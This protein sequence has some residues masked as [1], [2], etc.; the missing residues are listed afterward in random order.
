MT[1]LSSLVALSAAAA[2]VALQLPLQRPIKDALANPADDPRHPRPLVTS[3]LLQDTID[4]RRLRE[5]AEQLYALAQKSEDEFNHPTR[6]IGSAGHR[7]TLEYIKSEL[8]SLGSYYNVSEQEFDAYTGRVA[9]FRLVVMDAVPNTT[10]AFAL[11]P[12]TTNNEPVFGEVVLVHGT[13]CHESDYPR[14]ARSNIVL[15]KRG[16]C[17]FGEKSR[18]AGEAGAV[19]AV[20]YN[21]DKDE[22]HGTLGKPSAHHVATF[23]VGGKEAADWVEYLSRGKIIHGSAYMDASV[24][25]IATKNIIAQTVTGD[26]DNCVML[27]GH[28]DSVEEGPGINDDGSGS[29]SLVEVASQ[30]TKF[31]VANCVRFAWWSAEEEGLLGS[32]HYVGSLSHEDN[33]QIRLFMDYDTMASPNFAYQIY[34]ATDAENP[35][36]SE[37]LRD[38]YADWYT[39][40]GLHYTFIEFDGRSDYDPFVRAGIPAGGIA[41]GAEG[42]KT[43]QELELFGGVEGEWYDKNYHQIGD[44]VS[45]LNM[46]AWEVN[47]KLI[48][49]SV[50]TY[51]AS[52]KDF[53]ER[54]EVSHTVVKPRRKCNART[55]RFCRA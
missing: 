19:A 7:A 43:T 40:S 41:T 5:R 27:G 13:G 55:A 32:E 17:A 38:L 30:L 28:S 25:T 14:K 26:R 20:I 42:I 4:Q 46:T 49:H 45:N 9:E 54:M 33:L 50:A 1:R 24:E 22:L 39:N 10:T 3:H 52:F 8:T 31:R 16:D 53:P 23:G 2:A 37:S 44:D 11:T 15:I 35:A 21:T 12:P 48:A 47:T 6:V 29:L 18:L 36:G 51:A 34:N